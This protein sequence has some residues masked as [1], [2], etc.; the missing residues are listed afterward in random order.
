MECN[1]GT[2]YTGITKDITR[3]LKEHNSGRGSKYVRS[4][5]PAKVVYFETIINRSMALRREKEIKKLDKKRKNLL[6]INAQLY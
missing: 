3:R 1:D 4:R 6:I 5:L 2:L